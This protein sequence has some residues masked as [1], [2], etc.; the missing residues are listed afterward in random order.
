MTFNLDRPYV[1][2]LSKSQPEHIVVENQ[3]IDPQPLCSLSSDT[4]SIDTASVDLR[5]IPD[6]VNPIADS[7]VHLCPECT[8]VW[9]SIHEDVIREE[10][11]SCSCDR[12][13]SGTTYRC[14][15]ITSGSNARRLLH[16]NSDGTG[17][18]VCKDCYMFL[19]ELDQSPI[20]TPY[21]DAEPWNNS[22]NAV[23]S[24]NNR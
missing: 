21:E 14:G 12:F 10:T 22:V 2:S 6:D 23:Q 18:P 20:K 16:P 4:H 17:E 13:D 1:I 3:E 24:V 15:A 9:N 19:L 5:R 8:R 11:I 7:S